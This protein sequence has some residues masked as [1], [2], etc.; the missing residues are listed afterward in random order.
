[1]HSS[2]YTILQLLLEILSLF[3]HAP[4]SLEKSKCIC[5]RDLGTRARASTTFLSISS[6]GEIVF[7]WLPFTSNFI[8]VILIVTTFPTLKGLCF[9][10]HLTP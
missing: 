9:P 8:A 2:A 7:Y 5:M 10:T 4:S 6:D 3:S 1:M